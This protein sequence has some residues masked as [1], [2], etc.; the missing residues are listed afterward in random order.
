MLR[1]VKR[2]DVMKA[3]VIANTLALSLVGVAGTAF[4]E[5]ARAANTA[6]VVNPGANTNTANPGTS[7]PK[8]QTGTR[9]YCVVDTITGSRVPVKQCR[10]R[11]DWLK[12]G[13]DP[14]DPK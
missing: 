13:F 11:A 10:T 4:A 1:I 9:R 12:E 7:A 6:A 8:D 5:P 3:L 2:T 14:L